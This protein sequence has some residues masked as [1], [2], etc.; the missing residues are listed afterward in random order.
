VTTISTSPPSSASDEVAQ[1]LRAVRARIEEA[2]GDLTRV[3][4]VG[5]TKGFG[6]E[7]VRA[8]RAAG[9]VDIG[10]NY[11]NELVAKAADVEADAL[12]S[13]LRWHF[14]G[15]IQRNKVARLAPI[16]GMWQSVA[17][18]EE[19]ARIAR[20]APG[21]NVLVE[22]ETTGM[23]GRNGCPPDEVRA[24]VPRLRD[25]GLEVRGLM[26]VAGPSPRAA[27]SAFE[28]VRRLADELALE[29][30][31]MGMSDDLDVA[32]REGTT[33]VRIGRALFGERPVPRSG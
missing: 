22:V 33:M 3:R 26:T 28:T 32:V 6:P 24:L 8:A 2:G 14:L 21:A 7:A 9:L 1:R 20:F 25:A 17:R 19:G 15:T 23:A 10:E 12:P 30:R 29:E 5:V 27:E 18:A 11:A 16:V 4:I 13:M 31:S